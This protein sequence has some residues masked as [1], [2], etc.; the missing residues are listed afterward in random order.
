MDACHLLLGRPWQYSRHVI[1]DHYKNIYSFEKESVKIV[2]APFKKQFQVMQTQEKSNTIFESM[3]DN[4][5]QEYE[6]A[7]VFILIEEN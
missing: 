2:F 5:M 6:I 3:F 4:A 1:H 7:C